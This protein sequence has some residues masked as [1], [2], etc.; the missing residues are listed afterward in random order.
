MAV[1]QPFMSLIL[2][3]KMWKNMIQKF[4]Q[5][6]KGDDFWNLW[7]K[8]MRLYVLYLI[9]N[10]STKTSLTLLLMTKKLDRCLIQGWCFKKSLST[11]PKRENYVFQRC[12]NIASSWRHIKFSKICFEIGRNSSQSGFQ[13]GPQPFKHRQC[14]QISLFKNLFILNVLNVL[15]LKN[16]TDFNA[17]KQY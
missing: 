11:V 15:G 6:Q 3:K 9:W 10:Y 17:S 13:S 16:S 2:E 8:E 14:R 1:T 5:S 7:E 12:V 4:F